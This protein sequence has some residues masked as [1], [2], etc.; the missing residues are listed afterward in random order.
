MNL[1]TSLYAS[2]SGTVSA[3]VFLLMGCCVFMIKKDR[4]IAIRNYTNYINIL[5]ITFAIASIWCTFIYTF[6]EQGV[7]IHH[8]LGWCFFFKYW[9]RYIFGMAPW[10]AIYKIRMIRHG[11]WYHVGMNRWKIPGKLSIYTW[12]I[13]E[14]LVIPW[15]LVIV[16]TDVATKYYPEL[17]SKNCQDPGA[18]DF[19]L[20]SWTILTGF[21]SILYSWIVKRNIL[22]IYCNIY[23]KVM[24]SGVLLIGCSIAQMILE[25]SW[26]DRDDLYRFIFCMIFCGMHVLVFILTIGRDL[27]ESMVNGVEYSEN[28]CNDSQAFS[29]IL[30]YDVKDA[31]H[32]KKRRDVILEWIRIQEEVEDISELDD[33]SKKNYDDDIFIEM[34]EL[35]DKYILPAGMVSLYEHLTEWKK[36]MESKRLSDSLNLFTARSISEKY[37]SHSI[38]FPNSIKST[39]ENR[40]TANNSSSFDPEILYLID[41]FDRIWGDYLYDQNFID[42]KESG[43][44]IQRILQLPKISIPF[45]KEN[46]LTRMIEQIK[47]EKREKNN[48][49][50]FE[51]EPETPLDI[52]IVKEK[53]P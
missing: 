2:F 27:F 44:S 52:T 18:V 33:D 50:P 42:I 40:I 5:Q 46:P 36:T 43:T 21:T 4:Y 9:G 6:Y 28:R 37:L 1:L 41:M 11:L 26:F 13:S 38:A 25:S 8:E 23:D 47:K 29:D 35:V 48:K 19:L 12:M 32:S 3:V 51:E 45:K 39:L 31:F 16:G 17:M 49:I 24:M 10:M 7:D 14:T 15:I 30:V 34:K 20:Y 22:S 53:N